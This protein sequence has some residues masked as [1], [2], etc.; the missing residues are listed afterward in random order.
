MTPFVK[1]LLALSLLALAVVLVSAQER[2]NFSG[3]WVLD[4][5]P[6]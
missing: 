4:K 1:T 5:S 2:V 3:T 6:E